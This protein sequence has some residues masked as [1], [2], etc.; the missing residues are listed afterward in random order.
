MK[1]T[2]RIIELS[3]KL[4]NLGYKQDVYVGNWYWDKLTNDCHLFTYDKT[5]GEFY[6]K[7]NTKDDIP[8]PSLE[9]GLEWLRRQEYYSRLNRT[10][11]GCSILYARFFIG[12]EGAV[13]LR[14]DTPHEAVLMAMVKVLEGKQETKWT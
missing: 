10:E 1:P 6:G 3:R 5:H 14:A 11:H 13:N 7:E 8:I 12:I 4:K 2:E 9:D